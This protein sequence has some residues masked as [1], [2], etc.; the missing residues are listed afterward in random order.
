[1]AEFLV[2]RALPWTAVV[3]IV[4]QTSAMAMQVESITATTEH[5]PKVAVIPEWYF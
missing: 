5:R 4:V 2:H 3:G 1:M